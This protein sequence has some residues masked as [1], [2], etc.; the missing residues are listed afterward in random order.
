M[1]PGM[2]AS[3]RPGPPHRGAGDVHPAMRMAAAQAEQ[4]ANSN[5][6]GLAMVFLS[7]ANER[8]KL[9]IGVMLDAQENSLSLKK[10]IF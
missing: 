5:K 8:A 7:K 9:I 1:H 10:V 6:G 3:S 4:G 2:G